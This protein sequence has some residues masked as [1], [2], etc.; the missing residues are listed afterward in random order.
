MMQAA[1]LRDRDDL[2]DPARH[3]RAWVG[4]IL[5]ERKMRACSMVVVDVARQDAAQMARIEDDEVIQTLAANRA[6]QALDVGVLPGE[7]GAVT[8]SLMPIASTRLRKSVP[9]ETSRSRSR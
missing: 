3:D 2:P 1:D 5:V 9:Y 7:Q 8:T 4:A 6:D